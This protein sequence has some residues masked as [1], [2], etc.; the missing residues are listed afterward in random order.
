MMVSTA[1]V[2]QLDGI[3]EGAEV[4]QRGQVECSGDAA[5]VAGEGHGWDDDV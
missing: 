5:D 3:I 4:Q 2:V 1:E